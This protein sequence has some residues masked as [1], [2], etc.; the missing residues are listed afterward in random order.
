[1]ILIV[2]ADSVEKALGDEFRV[3]LRDK[4]NL[5][6]LYIEKYRSTVKPVVFHDLC[7]GVVELTQELAKSDN[8][9]SKEI[10]RLSH[11]GSAQMALVLIS[12]KIIGEYYD[13]RL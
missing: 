2:L 7:V 6:K 1:M 10:G 8:A 5:F 4:S 12:T 13:G 11:M 3:F 9:I